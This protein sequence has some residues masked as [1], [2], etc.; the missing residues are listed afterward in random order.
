MT[1]RASEGLRDYLLD[2]G[3][4]KDAM[5]DGILE[6]YSGSEPTDPEDATTG[7]LLV[8]ITDNSQAVGVGTGVDMAAT[9]SA[10]V[11]TKD[12]GQV[13]SGVVSITGKAGYYR[14]V[15]YADRNGTGGGSSTTALRVQGTIAEIGGD[16]N[17][18]DDDITATNTLTINVFSVALPAVP[19]S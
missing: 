3:S 7:T 19:V 17:L 13:W 9:A 8:Q 2:T 4:F 6:I 5:D 11:L 18:V 12:L 10:G 1:V 14:L 16:L 15:E